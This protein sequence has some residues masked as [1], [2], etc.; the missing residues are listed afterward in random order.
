MKVQTRLSLFCSVTFGIIFAVIS[1]LIYTLFYKNTEKSIY[2]S[3]KKTAYISALF[4]LEEDE[5]NFTEF[6]KVRMQFQEFVSDSSYQIYDI[7]N[8]IAYGSQT[9]TVP[10]DILNKIRQ[11]Q[12]LSFTTEDYLCHGIFYED[13]Q[14]DFVVVATE[15][16]SILTEQ[17]SILLWILVISFFI[18][19]IAIVIFSRWVSR[20]AYRPFGNV[21]K[22]VRNISTNNLDTQIESP[23]TKDELQDLT[24]TF[25]TLLTKISETFIIQKNFVSYVSHEFKTPL[26]S[27]QGNLEVFSLKDRT[28]EEYRQLSDKLIKQI[29]QLEEILNTLLIISDL[30]KNS[31]MSVQTRMDELIWEIVEK[32]SSRYP[33]SRV[34]VNIDIEPAD[35]EIMYIHRDPTQILMALY[36]LIE[37]AVKYS[38]GETVIVDLYKEESK[39]HVA[40]TDKGIGIPEDQL[41]DISKP[42][43]R[44]ENTNKI[45]GSGLG[46]S[47]A[48]RILEKNK[49]EYRVDSII[50]E[51]TT[52]LLIF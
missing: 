35:E 51:G 14:G 9:T 17:I 27:I 41:Q 12:S 39:L 42:F 40:I 25:N 46:L 31:D 29:S 32:I 7:T 48:L 50:N 2:D 3:L 10:A 26:A 38:H 37:N 24:D 45:Q 52:I 8:K 49:I 18:G 47:I 22:Q 21:I 19:L 16:K 13:N 28:P 44:A 43:Y 1:L 6:E 11:Q 36:N 33:R 30:S 15:K 23:D 5:L 20:V 4:Y 34:L